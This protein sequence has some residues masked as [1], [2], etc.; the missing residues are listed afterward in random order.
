M[1]YNHDERMCKILV[2]TLRRIPVSEPNMLGNE[3][4]Y[5]LD[6]LQSTWISSRG[7]YIE[8]FE[9]S[10]A[11]YLE[12]ETAVATS[13]GTTALHLILLALGIGPGD[14]VIV[15]TLTYVA[16]A[17]TITYVGAEPVFVDANEYDWNMD[18]DLIS[19]LITEKTKAIM[20]VHLYGAV[21]DI[22]SLKNI[23]DNHGLYLIEDA[24]EAL[25]AEYMNLKAGSFG[26][27]SAFSF[28]GNK[29]ITTGEGGLIATSNA[30]LADQ[31]RRL[32]NQG[33]SHH[34]RYW[35][36]VIGYNYRMT[37]IQ[38]AIG[39]AQVENI[40]FLTE[41]KRRIASYYQKYL[42]H[43]DIT[44]PVQ[45][46]NTKHGYWMYSILLKGDLSHIRDLLMENLMKKG[47]ETRPFFYPM[48][49]LPMFSVEHPNT[50]P[51]SE[52]LAARG[53]NIPSSTTLDTEDITY[54]SEVIIETLEE[55]KSSL[56]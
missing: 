9:R 6:C 31:I 10:M 38:A 7:E 24:A 8:K 3:E 12:V 41:Q 35:H 4:K 13:S 53:L 55:T 18:T 56:A 16:C 32:R 39:L 46:D 27:L 25:G 14:Q 51:V 40:S 26:D 11:Q 23:C 2:G 49:L 44:H 36:D 48:H 20:A 33:Q 19:D 30:S 5:V 45:R 28:F 42:Q 29:T 17:N 21:S 34:S 15:P 37:N 52:D 54:I 43:P 22:E 47:V 50:L 1:P